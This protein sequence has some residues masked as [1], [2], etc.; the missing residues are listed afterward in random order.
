MV[1]RADA[2][3]AVILLP[4]SAMTTLH[5]PATINMA[6]RG[7]AVPKLATRT[8]APKPI[9]TDPIMSPVLPMPLSLPLS[10]WACTFAV[11]AWL[12]SLNCF[13]IAFC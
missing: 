5:A 2:T 7:V 6:A 9:I 12:I 3:A 4:S 13:V 1:C 10:F 8:M 11:I